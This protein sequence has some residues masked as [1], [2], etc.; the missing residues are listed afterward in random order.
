MEKTLEGYVNYTPINPCGSCLDGGHC[1]QTGA[2]G[3]LFIRRILFP[4]KGCSTYGHY[5]AYDHVTLI[6]KG[7]VLAKSINKDGSMS[8]KIYTAPSWV[9]IPKNCRHE[10]IAL[11]DDSHGFCIFAIRDMSG[12]IQEVWDGKSLFPYSEI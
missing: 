6:T 8:D 7:S 1:D 3:N 5:H 12:E 11:E 2:F 4:S 10:F 9:P